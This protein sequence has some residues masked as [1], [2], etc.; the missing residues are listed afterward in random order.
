MRELRVEGLNPEDVSY[1][2]LPWWNFRRRWWGRG[3]PHWPACQCPTFPF[4]LIPRARKTGTACL[5]WCPLCPPPL[6]DTSRLAGDACRPLK[7]PLLSLPLPE[8][9]LP[10]EPGLGQ[11]QGTGLALFSHALHSPLHTSSELESGTPLPRCSGW[12]LSPQPHCQA[13]TFPKTF[14]HISTPRS[15]MA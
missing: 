2:F 12:L 3:G 13:H 14:G 1:I 9:R 10:P 6:G 4:P 8:L 7:L 11:P 15:S 5:R